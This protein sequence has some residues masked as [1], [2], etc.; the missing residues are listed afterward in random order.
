[1]IKCPT[2]ACCQDGHYSKFENNIQIYVCA[3]CG[4]EYDENWNPIMPKNDL[5]NCST[6]LLEDKN[7]EQ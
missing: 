2:L 1:M 6:V 4:S 5:I 7:K 3:D